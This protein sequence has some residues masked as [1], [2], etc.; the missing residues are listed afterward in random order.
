MIE[1]KVRTDAIAKLVET[2]EDLQGFQRHL[3]EVID[4]TAFKGSQRSGQFLKYIVE[5]ALAG[6]FDSL[7]ERSIGVE[8]FGRPASYDTGE[9]AIVRVTASDVRKRLLQHYG[10]YGT[11]SEFRISL[12]PGSY[13]PEIIR[14]ELYT[15]TNAF[16][17]IAAP[18]QPAEAPEAPL[19]LPVVTN[20]AEPQT[21]KGAS[22]RW[23]LFAILLVGLNLGL[24][25]I[26]GFHFATG[27]ISASTLPW[28]ALFHSERTNFLVTCDPN[29]AEIQGLTGS[30]VSVSDYANQQYLPVPNPLSPELTRV[31]R[32][33]LRGDKAANVDTQIIANVAQLAQ[34]NASKITVRAARDLRLSDMDTDNN[35]IF[36]GSPRTDP[37]TNL[38]HDQLDFRFAYDTATHQEIIQNAHPRP[39]ESAE[40]IPTAKGFATGQSF[41][42]ISFVRNPT[43]SGYVLILAGANA[44]GTKAAGEL[45]TNPQTLTAAL[46]NCGIHSANP[47]RS[48][49]ILLRLSTMA[50]SPTNFDVLAC[51][52]LPQE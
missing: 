10:S 36:L 46:K 23:Y 33:I 47:V 9:D 1:T 2:K 7:K 37:W 6:H 49:Q 43:H 13:I 26:F 11:A 35:F 18:G 40:Y 19:P 4:G 34:A 52:V 21:N 38:F 8:L 50:G 17:D 39:G 15:A 42:T 32:D 51:H 30:S 45:M 31:A 12:P 41:A 16:P 5:Q 29:I 25:S 48:F 44:E 22:K 24:W 14:D 3:K 28:S 20:A 27:G